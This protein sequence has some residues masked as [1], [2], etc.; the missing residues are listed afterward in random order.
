MDNNFDMFMVSV[1]KHG[2]NHMLLVSKRK[3]DGSFNII[4]AFSGDE[5][6]ELW[7][8]LITVNTKLMGEDET[9]VKDE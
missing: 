2:D 8:K 6:K 9:E 1:S 3:P 5:A 4:N 7:D